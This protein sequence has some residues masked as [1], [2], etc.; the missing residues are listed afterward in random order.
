MVTYVEVK[1]ETLL[2]LGVLSVALAF[3]LPRHALCLKRDLIWHQGCLSLI[4]ASLQQLRLFLGLVGHCFATVVLIK[5][6]QD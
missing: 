4:L 3:L 5:S 2:K 6:A 1:I